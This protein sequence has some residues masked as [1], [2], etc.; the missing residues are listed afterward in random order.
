MDLIRVRP[1]SREIVNER[2][3]ELIAL[4]GGIDAE[5]WRREQFEMELPDK[6]RHSRLAVLEDGGAAGFVVASR[7]DRHV[8]VHR[9]VVGSD[10]RR[11]GIGRRLIAAVAASALEDGLATMTLK[12]AARNAAAIRFY[13]RLGFAVA[14]RGPEQLQLSASNDGLVAGRTASG[15]IQNA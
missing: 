10:H 14:D 13:E 4:D 3:P 8:H 12:V 7:K 11:S 1:L 6:Y 2:L 5:G 9:L 15:L